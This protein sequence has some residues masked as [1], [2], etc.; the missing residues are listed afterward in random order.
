MF[1]IGITRLSKLRSNTA[2]FDA[3][4]A[5]EA[6]GNVL[7]AIRNHGS[8]IDV[9]RKTLT[10]LAVYFEFDA[11]T[12]WQANE[13]QSVLN[14]IHVHAAYGC[15]DEVKNCLRNPGASAREDSL[16]KVFDRQEPMILHTNRLH[17][18]M[19]QEMKMAFLIPVSCEDKKVGVLEIFVKEQYEFNGVVRSLLQNIG[20]QLGEKLYRQKLESSQREENHFAKAV[21]PVPSKKE[22]LAAKGRTLIALMAHDI[23]APICASSLLIE[24]LLKG[25]VGALSDEQQGLVNLIDFNNR[26]ILRLIKEALHSQRFEPG[27]NQTPVNLTHVL[28]SCSAEVAQELKNKEITLSTSIKAINPSVDGDEIAIKHVL[29]NILHNAI[30]F[31]G[32]NT[33]IKLSIAEGENNSF[34]ISIEDQGRGMTAAEQSRLF[35]PFCKTEAGKNLLDGDG[36]GLYLSRL[37]VQQHGGEIKVSSEPAK[38]SSFAVVLP[39]PQSYRAAS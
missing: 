26:E 29:L 36:I 2:S 6:Y 22:E 3:S 15:S 16:A 38:G 32:A 25:R 5:V 31:S 30:K 28:A 37:I 20:L 8:S 24:M 34:V 4:A 35:M 27:V 39:K 19:S 1:S 17:T 21:A 23:K 14:C 7:C 33:T 18:I 13:E 10:A 11:L 12:L 9:V